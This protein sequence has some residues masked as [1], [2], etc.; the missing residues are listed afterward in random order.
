MAEVQE[1]KTS[2]IQKIILSVGI[3]AVLIQ[4]LGFLTT[5]WSEEMIDSP[6]YE[7]VLAI[8]LKNT[9]DILMNRTVLHI[10]L[11]DR[12]INN[13]CRYPE[14]VKPCKNLVFRFSRE[15]QLRKV[16]KKQQTK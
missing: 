8:L 12:W 11:W 6:T 2:L 15:P 10:G 9:K 4:C 1:D 13:Q 14:T 16:R 7:V 5:H 3:T